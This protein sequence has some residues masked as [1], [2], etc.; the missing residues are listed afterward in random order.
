MPPKRAARGTGTRSAA[1]RAQ[2]DVNEPDDSAPAP[3]EAGAADTDD[4]EVDARAEPTRAVVL[5]ASAASQAVVAGILPPASMGVSADNLVRLSV[6]NL[7]HFS[8]REDFAAWRAQVQAVLNSARL[9]QSQQTMAIL[10]Q[11]R[12]E[13]AIFATAGLPPAETADALLDRLAEVYGPLPTATA[14][15]QLQ[16]ARQTPA[17]TV[18]SYYARVV[19]LASAANVADTRGI[20]LAGLL[21]PLQA[22]VHARLAAMGGAV[23]PTGELLRWAREAP[24]LPTPPAAV[25]AIGAPS[26]NASPRPIRCF[27]CRELGH[28]RRDCPYGDDSA[29]TRRTGPA[30]APRRPHAIDRRG[31]TRSD[32]QG[33]PWRDDDDVTA[34]RDG[35]R[36]DTRN[37]FARDDAPEP[38]D[39]ASKATS[40][41]R[42]G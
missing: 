2:L 8:G 22:L 42:R 24:P 23:P 7:P 20:F 3:V 29:P 27:G 6:S 12:D 31:F 39:E 26:D 25:A 9:P 13:A 4:S 35:R 40:G 41:T 18:A 34:P 38:R 33:R 15:L 10:L 1:K 36:D 32:G 11:L 14:M 28:I 21:P 30:N 37:N 5:D 19:R 16:M 17:E